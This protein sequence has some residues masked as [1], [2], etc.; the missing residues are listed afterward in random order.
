MNSHNLGALSVLY[1]RGINMLGR[2]SVLYT[3]E[4]V[5]G[6]FSESLLTLI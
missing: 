1:E 6:G 3:E 5:P 2:I 4:N